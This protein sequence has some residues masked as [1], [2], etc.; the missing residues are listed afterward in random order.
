[1]LSF[2][3]RRTRFCK[4]NAVHLKINSSIMNRIILILII[5]FY[6]LIS[7]SQPKSINSFIKE[8]NSSYYMRGGGAV[9]KVGN[10]GNVRIPFGM[11]YD[12]SAKKETSQFLN[13]DVKGSLMVTV[14]YVNGKKSS[15][16]NPNR[17]RLELLHPSFEK[18]GKRRFD[19]QKHLSRKVENF[20]Y[21]I[22]IIDEYRYN[23]FLLE[24]NRL[25]VYEIKM[26]ENFE[27]IEFFKRK[28]KMK[29]KSSSFFNVSQEPNGKF[30]LFIDGIY[31]KIKRRRIKKI[32]EYD[33]NSF[34]ITNTNTKTISAVNRQAVFNVIKEIESVEVLRNSPKINF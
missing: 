6:S 34:F 29:V 28:R 1:M 20:N 12:Q 32:K 9:Y 15:R 19:L 14:E 33:M 13:F 24:D 16:L 22:V 4:I 31:Y 7:Y 11:H 10:E 8:D 17:F 21:D 5:I 2:R 30:L 18:I 23:L 27:G 3:L 26:S 25:E